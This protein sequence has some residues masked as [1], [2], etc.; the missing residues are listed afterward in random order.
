[1]A[2]PYMT[3][4]E[5]SNRLNEVIENARL[6]SDDFAARF[7]YALGGVLALMSQATELNYSQVLEAI[8]QLTLP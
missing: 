5:L 3:N 6:S 7:C 8:D 1:M 4:T 2:R